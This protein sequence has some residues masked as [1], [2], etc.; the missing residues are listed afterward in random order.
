MLLPFSQGVD[1]GN[2]EMEIAG[3]S[4]LL[5]GEDTGSDRNQV[6]KICQVDVTDVISS[7]TSCRRCGSLR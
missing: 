5:A 2:P 1:K 3:V 4:A 7:N 6:E